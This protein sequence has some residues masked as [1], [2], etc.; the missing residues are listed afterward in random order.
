MVQI[1]EKQ[2]DENAPKPRFA[3]LLQGQKIQTITLQDAIDLFKLPRQVGEWEGKEIVASVGRFGPY[4]RFD[5]KFTSIKKTD[6]EDPVTISL[7][8]SIELIKIKIKADKERLISN[9]EGDPLIQVLNGRYGPFIQ[10]TPLKEKKINVKIPK[11]TE[12]RDLTR[13]ECI[14]LWNNQPEKKSRFKKK[15]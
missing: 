14:V 11:G 1:G 2:E 5:G 9:F 4:L 3:S 7:D 10:V 15:S 13:E 6:E 12:P 8:R